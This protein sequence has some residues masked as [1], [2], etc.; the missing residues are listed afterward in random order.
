MGER[1]VGA[2]GEEGSAG[3]RW[4][5]DPERR[6]ETIAAL[7]EWDE[8]A[9]RLEVAYWEGDCLPPED[10]WRVLLEVRPTGVTETCVDVPTSARTAARLRRWSRRRD[11]WETPPYAFVRAGSVAAERDELG[12]WIAIDGALRLGSVDYPTTSLAGI[13]GREA[14]VSLDL[15]YAGGITDLSPLSRLKNLTA[16]DLTGCG[17]FTELTPLA[18][19]A[20][21]TLVLPPGLEA[22]SDLT[23]LADMTTLELLHLRRCEKLANLAPLARLTAMKCLELSQLDALVDLSP[24]AGLT[25]LT[26]LDLSRC[27][28]VAELSPLAGLTG[29]TNL[30][31]SHCTR[32]MDLAPLA[33]LTALGRLQLG[34]CDVR[35]VSPLS[36]LKRLTTLD[37]SSNRVL[38]VTALSE[39]HGLTSL[40]LSATRVKDLSPLSALTMLTSLDLSYCLDIEDL[41][42]VRALRALK[43]LR[44]GR[45]VELRDL[46]PLSA[47][48]ALTVLSLANSD[49]LRDLGPLR[50]LA[51]LAEL[52]LSRSPRLA[53]VAPIASLP[54]LT[55]LDLSDSPNVRDLERLVDAPALRELEFDRAAQRDGVMLAIATRRRDPDLAD[56]VRAMLDSFDLSE[57]PRVHAERVIDALVVLP[58]PGPLLAPVARA[59]R[60]RPSDDAEHALPAKTWERFLLACVARPDPEL[61]APFEIALGE[62]P[63]ADAERILAPSL[64]ALADVPAGAVTWAQALA[65]AA[66]RPL[67]DAPARAIAP[68]AA[69]FFHAHQRP[70][71]VEAWIERGTVRGFDEWRDRIFVALVGRAL[72]VGELRE[73]RRLAEEIRTPARR[74]EARG[75]IARSLAVT[76]DF[77]GAGEELDRMVIEALRAAAAAE[78]LTAAP[79]MAGDERAALSLLLALDGDPDRLAAV[80][81]RVVEQAPES[82]LAAAMARAF[83]PLAP[84]G[85]PEPTELAAALDEVLAA[86]AVREVT[87]PRQLASLRARL[88]AEPALARRALR[89]VAIELL[90]G[91]ALIDHEEAIA[92]RAALSGSDA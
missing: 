41:A 4:S 45:G 33:R 35:D 82:P 29:L 58:E 50:N 37:V 90:R 9:A 55:K 83:A 61:R 56:R 7:R 65:G 5:V 18:G 73:A 31:L 67:A 47:L 28:E 59:F 57:T 75:Q 16:L 20:L 76:E 42:P 81:A 68:S 38:D 27:S 66:L 26:D 1:Y 23:P 78:L 70:E 8:D 30:D 84:L 44:L 2:M 6:E 48:T 91:E 80:V 51:A 85:T 39:L 40:D 10:A 87:K 88:A 92:L 64:V 32:I 62:L 71:E 46:T 86:A 13:E 49:Q 21:R 17:R 11:G 79:A 74:D 25:G 3:G 34:S 14:L 15:N 12:T 60:A 77:R 53:L 43:R 36:R 72:R 89:E 22:L 69:L 63:P 52:D 19:M 24:L 54:N